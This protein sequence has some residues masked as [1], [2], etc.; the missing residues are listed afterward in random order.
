MGRRH[1]IRVC[2]YAG[3][4]TRVCALYPRLA[5]SRRVAGS[6]LSRARSFVRCVWPDRV[7]R[8]DCTRARQRRVLA[9]T[10][11]KW[12]DQ[13]SMVA[14]PGL[15]LPCPMLQTA[16]RHRT[17]VTWPAS[18][19]RMSIFVPYFFFCFYRIFYAL[20]THRQCCSYAMRYRN[21]NLSFSFFF[22]L[23]FVLLAFLSHLPCHTTFFLLSIPSFSF[24]RLTTVD[25]GLFSLLFFYFTRP[26]FIRGCSFGAFA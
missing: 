14:Q 25:T 17:A 3:T 21:T 19:R 20:L 16:N 26:R 12:F 7:I 23:F 8:A 18:E 2:V 15:L 6:A 13:A 10:G 11:D 9:L 22:L 4:C 1:A 5:R 24:H